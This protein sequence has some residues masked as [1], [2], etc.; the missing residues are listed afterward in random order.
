[1]HGQAVLKRTKTRNGTVR[2]AETKRKQTKLDSFKKQK[3]TQRLVKRG[4]YFK[5]KSSSSILH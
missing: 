1:M 4:M 5:G 3:S 2:A